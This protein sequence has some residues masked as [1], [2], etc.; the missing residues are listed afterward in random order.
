MIHHE[1][2]TLLKLQQEPQVGQNS[3]H[4]MEQCLRQYIEADQSKKEKIKEFIDC[5]VLNP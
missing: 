1:T 3:N 4:L 2:T 5:L